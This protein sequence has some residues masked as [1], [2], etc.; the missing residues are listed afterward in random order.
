MQVDI[1]PLSIHTKNLPLVYFTHILN[2]SVNPLFCVGITDLPMLNN[3]QSY[4]GCTTDKIFKDKPNIFD[5]FI[6]CD[7][8]IAFHTNDSLLQSIIKITR[9]DRD[10]LKKPMT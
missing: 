6:D 8:Q 5:V 3:E 9:N 2:Q 10:R 1:F 7:K 4:I